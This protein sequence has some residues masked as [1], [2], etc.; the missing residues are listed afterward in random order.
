MKF[1]KLCANI[2]VDGAALPE[3]VEEANQQESTVSCWI[4]SAV[5]QVSL[6][7]E[8]RGVSS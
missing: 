4:P 7:F 8:L 1:N 5:A 6:V 2:V 3:Y